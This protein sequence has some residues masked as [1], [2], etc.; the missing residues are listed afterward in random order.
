M[1]VTHHY[2]VDLDLAV[3]DQES[4]FEQGVEGDCEGAVGFDGKF[5]P[6]ERGESGEVDPR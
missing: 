1:V 6:H 3:V 4:V 2:P 5:S